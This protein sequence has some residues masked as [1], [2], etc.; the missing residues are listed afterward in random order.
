MRNSDA[1]EER[2]TTGNQAITLENRL[3]GNLVSKNVVSVS[4]RNF[5]DVEISLL[6]K[7]LNF[8]PKC[9]DFNKAKLKMVLETF[10]KMLHFI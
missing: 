4:K 8:V 2:N 1:E 6:S 7:G 10:G 5:D 9:N 3:K